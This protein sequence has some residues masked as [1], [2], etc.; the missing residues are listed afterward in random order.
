MTLA[1]VEATTVWTMLA[2]MQTNAMMKH[3]GRNEGGCRHRSVTAFD[4]G[5]VTVRAKITMIATVIVAI[6]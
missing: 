5:A 2:V 1:R 6:R 3:G 4:G